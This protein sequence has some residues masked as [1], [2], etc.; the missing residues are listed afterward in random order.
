MGV[1]LETGVSRIIGHDTLVF[2]DGD[3]ASGQSIYHAQ[4]IGDE[5]LDYTEIIAR[6]LHQ[7]PFISHY[8]A[9]PGG[10][11]VRTFD[12]T[13]RTIWQRKEL[14]NEAFVHL[15][16]EEQLGAE[17]PSTPG[18]IRGFLLN[19]DRV[20]FTNREVEIFEMLRPH[21]SA[22]ASI[23]DQWRRMDL[24]P[25]GSRAR[26]TVVLNADGGV[27][28]RSPAAASLLAGCCG[29]FSGALPRE[30]EDWIRREVDVFSQPSLWCSP[31]QSLRIEGPE[32]TLI[33]R[34][35]S[36]PEGAGHVILIEERASAVRRTEAIQGL[37]TRE[38]EVLDWIACG[39]SNDEIARIL[40]VS[41][42]TVKNHVKR[43]LTILGV[44]N[45]T[46]AASLHLREQER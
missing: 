22:A 36:A 18:T 41:V 24:T 26:A 25:G 2:C 13:S 1:F 17:I 16:L 31:R 9:C 27:I 44:D 19:R 39:K 37:S 6:Y 8:I 46:S 10:P 42:H 7:T 33:L 32:T 14:Y 15:G 21:I 30:V 29:P 40:G 28:L 5:F 34:L 35:A 3:K 45:R 12:V 38:R 4:S 43:V 23:A 11:A 20:S